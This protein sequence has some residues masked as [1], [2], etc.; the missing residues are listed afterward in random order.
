MLSLANARSLE[1]MQNWQK[2]AQNILPNATFAYVCE[3]KI[4]GLAMAPTDPSLQSIGLF[5]GIGPSGVVK[6]LT[7]TNAEIVEERAGQVDLR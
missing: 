1:D 4:D 6:N 5:T 2:R 7:F 3:L